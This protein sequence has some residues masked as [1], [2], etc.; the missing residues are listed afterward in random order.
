MILILK[1]NPMDRTF[2]RSIFEK[3]MNEVLINEY[4]FI[5]TELTFDLSNHFLFDLIYDFLIHN[6]YM[7]GKNNL[8]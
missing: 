7:S 4:I 3:K 8:I 6:N 2:F 1:N 5:I